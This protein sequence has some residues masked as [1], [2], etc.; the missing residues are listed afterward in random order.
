MNN[1][2]DDYNNDNYN[3]LDQ[4]RPPDPVKRETLIE[5]FDNFNN[6]YNN[7]FDN[8]IFE[9][10]DDN[11]DDNYNQ[12]DIEFHRVLQLSRDEY[13]IVAQQNEN[14]RQKRMP[15]LSNIKERLLRVKGFDMDNNK[16]YEMIISI[17]EMYEKEKI[18]TFGV[19]KENYTTIFNVTKSVRFDKDEI[20]L[21][22]DI[23]VHL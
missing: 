19:D 14:A 5:Q 6:M 1:N 8:N 20:E 17:I 12:Y 9:D 4:I 13:E 11:I 15:I 3:N 21:L 18:N 22:K 16:I 23:I 2:N 10:I 7:N